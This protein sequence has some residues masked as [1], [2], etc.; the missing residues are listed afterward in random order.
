MN[1]NTIK[2]LR[3]ESTKVD[4]DTQDSPIEKLNDDCLVQIFNFLSIAERIRIQKVSTTWR[5]LAKESWYKVKGLRVDPKFLGLKPCGTKH[6]YPDINDHVL[7]SILEKCGRYLEKI[8]ISYIDSDCYL[9]SVAKYCPNIKSISCHSAS[10]NGI[11]L[12]SEY[13]RNITEFKVQ[14]FVNY[15]KIEDALGCL[16]SKNKNFRVVNIEDSA[17][18]SGECL[19]KLPMQ[20]MLT[21]SGHPVAV[22]E[23]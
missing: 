19:L 18:L 12:L 5:D 11:Q 13:C 16:F 6:Q 17:K 23:L 10:S 22:S 7:D 15:D 21:T 9:A 1:F 4:F 2:K 8:D 14:N 20:K 3:T